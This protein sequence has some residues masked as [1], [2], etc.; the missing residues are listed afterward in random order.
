MWRPIDGHTRT[1][2]RI[3]SSAVL[4]AV[5]F[6]RPL[7]PLLASLRSRETSP[8]SWPNMSLSLIL[9][10]AVRHHDPVGNFI[11]RKL[12]GVNIT[13]AHVSRGLCYL[14]EDLLCCLTQMNVPNQITTI[15]T[16]FFHVANAKGT[17]SRILS[18]P[19]AKC[20]IYD[21]SLLQDLRMGDKGEPTVQ[22][23]LPCFLTVLFASRREGA[24]WSGCGQE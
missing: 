10:I 2:H 11:T 22:D 19:M 21:P 23:F 13:I 17:P 15:L 20:H 8:L 14:R 1:E 5:Q 24:T 16:N 9:T 18:L 3:A 4:H 6:G 7:I 12:D